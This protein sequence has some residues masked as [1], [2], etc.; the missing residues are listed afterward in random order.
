MTN[1]QFIEFKF[2][3]A[4]LLS[5]YGVAITTQT[6]QCLM[7]YP[8]I[9]FKTKDNSYWSLDDDGFPASEVGSSE[10]E[11]LAKVKI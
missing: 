4:K 7:E 2:E 6:A 1:E 10:A 3:L 9:I 8:A 11:C 5:K